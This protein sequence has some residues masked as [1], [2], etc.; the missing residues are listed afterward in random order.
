VCRPD[1]PEP[2]DVRREDDRAVA[3]VVEQ[4]ARMQAA[5]PV[6]VDGLQLLPRCHTTED[7]MYHRT[8]QPDPVRV[9]AGGRREGFTGGDGHEPADVRREDGQAVAEVAEPA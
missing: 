6:L 4:A 5:A 3:E 2:A 1:G 9:R 7:R 8:P